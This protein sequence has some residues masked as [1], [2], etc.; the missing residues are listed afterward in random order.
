[1]YDSVA[2][3]FLSRVSHNV[4]GMYKAYQF[5]GSQNHNHQENNDECELNLSL[6]G[7]TL[8]AG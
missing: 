5:D 7:G 3:A 2:Q 1:M 8:Q 6:S 4:V